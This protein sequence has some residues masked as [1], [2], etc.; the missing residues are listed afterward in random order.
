M[1]GYNYY[2]VFTAYT[3]QGA[4][5]VLFVLRNEEDTLYSA[6]YNYNRDANFF[7]AYVNATLTSKVVLIPP[8]DSAFMK[9]VDGSTNYYKVDY[10]PS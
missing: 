8:I 3:M 9:A 4:A 2:D 7:K 10:S 6:K 5:K 1:F